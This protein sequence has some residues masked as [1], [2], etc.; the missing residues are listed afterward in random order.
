MEHATQPKLAHVLVAEQ[1]LADLGGNRFLAMTGARDLM[2]SDVECGSL[3]FKI[4]RNE[5]GVTAVEVRLTARDTYSV[6]FFAGRGVKM[7]ERCKVNDV[8]TNALRDVF[9]GVTGMRTSL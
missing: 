8:Y 7:L 3:F 1:I 4:G 2:H 5:A 9:E 6:R